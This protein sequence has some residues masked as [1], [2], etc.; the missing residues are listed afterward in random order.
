MQLA[1]PPP[2]ES[3]QQYHQLIGHLTLHLVTAEGV[4]GEHILNTYVQQ[5]MLCALNV[6]VGAII[7]YI[8]S[9]PQLQ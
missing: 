6:T 8:V 1:S 9:L 7:V 5:K 3:Y 2:E 4:V